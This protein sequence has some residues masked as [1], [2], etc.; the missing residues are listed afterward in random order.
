[1]LSAPNISRTYSRRL[2]TL[3]RSLSQSRDRGVED[4]KGNFISERVPV[5]T[6][7]DGAGESVWSVS[8]PRQA[9]N[10]GVVTAL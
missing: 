7:L 9:K 1:L 6:D 3:V 2:A 8:R 5:N 10:E 4:F